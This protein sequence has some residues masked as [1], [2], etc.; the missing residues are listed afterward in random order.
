LYAELNRFSE[1]YRAPLVL[2]YLQ[3][4]TQAAA[5]ALLGVSRAALKKRLERARALL[6]QRLIR[7]GFGPAAVLAASTWPTVSA[8]AHL[9]ATL[10]AST[11]EAALKGAAGELVSA[12]VLALK[13]EVI[14]ALWLSEFTAVRVL[15]LLVGIAATA[16]SALLYWAS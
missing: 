14:K 15:I 1:R 16:C 11:A 9:P 2:C 4:Q 5:A 13:A 10:L 6:R 8:S 7:R 3:G 12:R